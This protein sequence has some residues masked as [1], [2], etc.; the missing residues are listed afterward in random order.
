MTHK[1]I[2]DETISQLEK[3][4]IAKSN[5]VD[6]WHNNP[7]KSNSKSIDIWKARDFGCSVGELKAYTKVRSLLLKYK[8]TTDAILK[9]MLKE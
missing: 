9:E 7:S 5:E 2:L 1:E 4:W 6:D 8:P 3:L